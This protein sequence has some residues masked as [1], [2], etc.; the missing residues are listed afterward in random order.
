MYAFGLFVS[1]HALI[2]LVVAGSVASLLT[3]GEG[4]P[5]AQLPD[6]NRR[7]VKSIKSVWPRC[8]CCFAGTHKK[9]GV[10]NLNHPVQ[11]ATDVAEFYSRR[12]IYVTPAE[13][14]RF[15]SI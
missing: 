12:R 7:K 8:V 3:G 14:L 1:C 4:L 10:H 5:I 13:G 11:T 6:S 15:S 2:D 9:L